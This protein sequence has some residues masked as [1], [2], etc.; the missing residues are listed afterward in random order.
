ME[1]E[2]KLHAFLISVLHGCEWS[3]SCTGRCTSG[4]RHH[5]AHWIGDWVRP[6]P[7]LPRWRRE[8]FLPLPGNKPRSSRS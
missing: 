5:G 3:A 6:R 8:K 2:V 7:G 4:E 1:V